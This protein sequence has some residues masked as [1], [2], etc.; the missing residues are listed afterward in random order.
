VTGQHEPPK[1]RHAV[2]AFVLLYLIGAGA[3]A[4]AH[5]FDA[6]AALMLFGIIGLSAVVTYIAMGGKT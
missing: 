6:R 3:L 4:L 2:A 1:A 5:A